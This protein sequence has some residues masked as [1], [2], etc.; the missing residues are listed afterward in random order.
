[1]VLDE[2]VRIPHDGS[3]PSE[4]E[5]PDPDEMMIVN[6]TRDFF[7]IWQY[8]TDWLTVSLTIAGDDVH[9]AYDRDR[10]QISILLLHENDNQ[11]RKEV[12]RVWKIHTS[13]QFQATFVPS[14]SGFP[15][16]QFTHRPKPS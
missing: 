4:K 11:A 6:R 3:R 15:A 16:Y 5:G 8:H 7:M 9:Q 10:S 13:R 1:M 12:T 14:Y 2:W